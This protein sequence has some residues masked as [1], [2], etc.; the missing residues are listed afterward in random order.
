[1][2]FMSIHLQTKVKR[3]SE[4]DQEETETW[5]DLEALKKLN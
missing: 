5:I 2:N 4:I 1:M 3:T